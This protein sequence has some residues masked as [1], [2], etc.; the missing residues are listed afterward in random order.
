M[1]A[2]WGWAPLEGLP[3]LPAAQGQTGPDPDAELKDFVVFVCKTAGRVDDRVRHSN[4]QYQ[5]TSSSSSTEPRGQVAA[6]APRRRARFYCP[7]DRK[8][9]LDLGFF[10]SSA[11]GSMR[12]RLRTG[13]RDR[14]RVRTPRAEPARRHGDVQ[15]KQSARSQAATPMNFSIRRSTASIASR[16]SG[17]TRPTR[18]ICSKA[19]TWKRASPRRRGRVAIASRSSHGSINRET[20]RTARREPRTKWFRKASTGVIRALATVFQAHLA[21]IGTR[22]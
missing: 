10:A 18:R 19:A 13:L 15:R 20:G 2:G 6:S 21:R 9:Y 1:G 12:P 17:P 3:E 16:A 11:L 14:A 4:K 8:V 7:L 22:I 5:P